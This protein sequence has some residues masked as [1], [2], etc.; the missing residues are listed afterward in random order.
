MSSYLTVTS[1]GFFLFK[2][3]EERCVQKCVFQD[4]FKANQT[5]ANGDYVKM[6]H[7]KYL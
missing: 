4:Y 1:N 5:A 2:S 7:R 6:L 3:F